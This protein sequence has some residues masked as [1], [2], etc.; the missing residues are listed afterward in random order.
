VLEVQAQFGKTK[1]QNLKGKSMTLN[2]SIRRMLIAVSS[3]TGIAA[4]LAGA[5][6]TGERSSESPYL[7]GTKPGA[8]TMSMLT[9]GDAVNFKSDGV[10]PYRMVGL[11]RKGQERESGLSNLAQGADSHCRAATRRGNCARHRRRIRRTQRRGE[12]F[13]AYQSVGRQ[14]QIHCRQSN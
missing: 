2:N 9:V 8:V 4:A 5:A 6:I 10:T 12:N 7:V 14:I 13:H 11:A 1:I 3:V